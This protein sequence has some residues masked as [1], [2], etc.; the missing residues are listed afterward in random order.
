MNKIIL[1]G[2]VTRDPKTT[3][4]ISELGTAFVNTKFDH[5]VNRKTKKI[6]YVDAVF[7]HC[8]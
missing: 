5:E 1:L 6:S 2:N 4:K 3:R 7:F 8:T